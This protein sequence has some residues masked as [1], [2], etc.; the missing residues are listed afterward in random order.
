MLQRLARRLR[1]LIADQIDG[2]DLCG[3]LAFNV[4]PPLSPGVGPT[5]RK[6]D[7][8]RLLGSR[9]ARFLLAGRFSLELNLAL[10]SAELQPRNSFRVSFLRRKAPA[11]KP[12]S[13]HTRD[14]A[15]D[16]P[17]FGGDPF[18]AAATFVDQH[19]RSLARAPAARELSFG[20]LR[21]SMC[22]S[23]LPPSWWRVTSTAAVGPARTATRRAYTSR[24]GA[25]YPCRPCST[26][27]PTI[28]AVGDS[29][30]GGSC[31]STWR[32]RREASRVRRVELPALDVLAVTPCAA[33]ASPTTSQRCR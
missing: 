5:A 31:P 14:R 1:A 9:G 16:P 19:D 18:R 25:P 11:V 6:P 28:I 15:R 30:G 4:P 26:T 27:Q 2:K 33:V 8:P 10:H 17:A 3:C 23:S 22:A 21:P 24:S 32:F 29:R 7:A 20:R 13:P 12:H